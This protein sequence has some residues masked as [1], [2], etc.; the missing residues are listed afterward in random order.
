MAETVVRQRL[1]EPR[2]TV[3]VTAAIATMHY[4]LNDIIA[5]FLRK[6]PKVDVVAQTSDAMVDICGALKERGV[7]HVHRAT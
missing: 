6:F 5:D 1:S 3:R 2:G 4:A 7:P